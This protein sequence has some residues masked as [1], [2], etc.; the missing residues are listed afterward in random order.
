MPAPAPRELPAKTPLLNQSPAEQ[1]NFASAQPDATLGPPLLTSFAALGDNNTNIPPD[2]HGAAGP[3]HLMTMLNTQV[4]IQS[5]A[6]GII[7]TSSLN[8]FWSPT[9][10]SDIFDP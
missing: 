4:R 5:L 2:T 7:S 10:A 8:S 1:Q 9:C 6:G 3:G